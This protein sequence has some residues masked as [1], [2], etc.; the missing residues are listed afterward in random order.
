MKGNM[1]YSYTLKELPY[2]TL[3]KIHEFTY[4]DEFALKYFEDKIV[5]NTGSMDYK[6]NVKGK[7]TDWNFF[8]KDPEFK[9]F[10][11]DIFYPAII[12]HNPLKGFN[13]SLLQVKEA[14]GNLLNK[15]DS[16]QKHHHRNGYY[17]TVIYFDNIAPL[18][19]DIGKIETFRGKVVTI[20]GFLYHWVDPVPGDRINL[21]FNWSMLVDENNR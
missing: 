15:G 8:I 1:S 6:T 7:M 20:D 12:K 21:V 14:W 10:I 13:E 16:V 9:L 18:Q 2:T 4:D 17:S 3:T 5:K 19:T 11:S